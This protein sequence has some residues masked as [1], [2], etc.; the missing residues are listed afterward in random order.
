[1]S[2]QEAKA[3]YARHYIA[4]GEV[5]KYLEV[6]FTSDETWN[7]EIDTRIAKADAFL[8]ELYRSVVTKRTFWNT[9]KLS[10]FES[11]FDPI[12]TYGQMTDKTLSQTQEAYVGYLRSSR[13]SVLL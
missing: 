12:L 7:R 5:H 2:P 3:V 10:V 1:M 11:V 4:A 6:G 13:Q 8:H 9:A